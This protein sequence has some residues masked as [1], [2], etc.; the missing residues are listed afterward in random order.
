MGKKVVVFTSS[1]RKN[2]N[3]NKMADSFIEAAETKGHEVTR[4]DL[5]NMNIGPCHA[6]RKCYTNDKPCIFDDDWNRIA[7]VLLEADAVIY[8]MP[9]YWYGMPAVIKAVIDKMY[10]YSGGGLEYYDKDCGIIACCE[11]MTTDAFDGLRFPIEMT[12]NLLSW[13][14]IGEVLV[15]SV[16]EAGAIDRTD[17]CARAAALADKL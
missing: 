8:V 11:A 13:N 9:L 3:S 14:M 6:C 1:G 2:G 16:S 15:T 4:F 10:C 17:G 12:A 5:V 7:P